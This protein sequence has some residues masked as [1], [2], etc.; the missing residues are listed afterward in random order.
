MRI[1][2][3]R[4]HYFYFSLEDKDFETYGNDTCHRFL[5]MFKKEMGGEKQ[6]FWLP[7]MKAW[8]ISNDCRKHF[9]QLLETYFN[10][11]GQGDIFGGIH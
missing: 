1:T 2:E 4:G 7:R 10:L 5:N 9:D 6:R 8:A 11:S 3:T